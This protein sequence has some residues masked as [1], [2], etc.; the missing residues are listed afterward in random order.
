MGGGLGG[1]FQQGGFT[2]GR[3]PIIVGER[4]PE[5]FQPSGA[6]RVTPGVPM[7]PPEVNIKVV[8]VIDPEEI[9]AQMTGPSGEQAIINVLRRNRRTVRQMIGT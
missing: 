9:T 6:G 5:L 4:G 1:L 7:A 8:N 3:K 2:P